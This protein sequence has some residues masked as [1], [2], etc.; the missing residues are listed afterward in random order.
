MLVVHDTS[1]ARARG[2]R[3]RLDRR[4][5]AG[6]ARGVRR[7]RELTLYLTTGAVYIGLG[8]AFPVFLYSWIVGAGFLMV[9]V[10]II[11]AL[12]RRLRR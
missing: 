7:R 6:Q 9:G 5:E 3:A 8:V 2:E 4:R 11:P 1:G 12:I 10:W